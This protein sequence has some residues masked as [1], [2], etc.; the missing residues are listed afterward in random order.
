MFNKTFLCFYRQRY[1]TIYTQT[2]KYFTILHS[3][4]SPLKILHSR[5]LRNQGINNLKEPWSVLQNN[6]VRICFRST[7]AYRLRHYLPIQKSF[8]GM[9]HKYWLFEN[10]TAYWKKFGFET[11]GTK[12]LWPITISNKIYILKPQQ[13]VW[14]KSSF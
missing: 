3:R 13:Q 10:M 1:K 7:E 5:L 8:F 14:Q 6:G 9:S 12:L 4:M 11:M 2:I